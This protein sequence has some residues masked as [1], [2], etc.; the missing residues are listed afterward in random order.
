MRLMEWIR[1]RGQKW[2]IGIMVLFVISVFAGLGVS[3]FNF[4]RDRGQQDQ[5]KAGR[6][7]QLNDDGEYKDT[8]M[9]VNGRPIKNE[10]LNN[11][12]DGVYSRASQDSND[13]GYQF[14]AYGEVAMYLIR[15]ELV[16]A[17]GDE[18]GVKVTGDDLKEEKENVTTQYMTAGAEATSGNVVGDFAKRIGAN[19]ERQKAFEEYLVRNG[20]TEEQWKAEQTRA[21]K[22]RK[23]IEAVQ[24]KLDEAKKIEA[25]AAKAKVDEDLAAGMSFEDVVK[26]HSEGPAAETGGDIGTWIQRGLLFDEQAEDQLFATPKG[27]LSEWIEIPAGFQRFEVYDKLTAEGPE[28]EA[29]KPGIIEALKT[30]KGEDYAPTDEEVAKQYEKVKARQLVIKTTEV[31]AAEQQ[32]ADEMQSA[33][34]EVNNPI[35]LAYQ[36]IYADRIQPPA[37]FEQEQLEKIAQNSALGEGFDYSLLALKLKNGLPQEPAAAEDQSAAESEGT[38]VE[39]AS[40]IKLEPVTDENSGE[41]PAAEEGA[42]APAEDAAADPAAAPAEDAE[43][44]NPVMKADGTTPMPIYALG[45][46]LFKLALQNDK[47]SDASF[48]HYMLAKTYLDW[49]KDED[50]YATQPMDRARARQEIEQSLALV[51]KSFEYS[52]LVHANRGLNLAW[53]EQPDQARTELELAQ[54]YAPNDDTAEVWSVLKDAYDVLDDTEK[55]AEID[56]LMA[57]MRQERFQRQIQEAQARQQQQQQQQ[58]QT[59]FAPGAGQPPADGDATPQPPAGQQPAPAPPVA[60]P[61][62][63]PAQAPPAAPQAQGG[64]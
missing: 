61:A 46:G 36:A 28:F 40:G 4:T 6:Q 63:P 5:A 62:A 7:V 53:L 31:G 33:K 39:P 42:A 51:V 20:L 23:T 50:V 25:T 47:Q 16:M 34:V 44:A 55:V 19:R 24:A 13:P 8:A 60:P 1:R 57:Q 49:L 64:E 3:T 12:L 52:P 10:L 21:I 45:I 56:S 38:G 48:L 41:P 58:A 54:K 59:P 30:D 14:Q 35:I 17:K 43:P 26:K 37:G 27:E 2:L 11:T 32:I 29:A 9:V 18:L 22:T 15:Q